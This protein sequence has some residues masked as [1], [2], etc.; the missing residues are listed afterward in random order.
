MACFDRVRYREVALG[1]KW[2]SQFSD[3]RSDDAKTSQPG[4]HRA[5]VEYLNPMFYHCLCVFL[6]I[7]VERHSC[8]KWDVCCGL[9]NKWWLRHHQR[10]D[11]RLGAIFRHASNR[12]TRKHSRNIQPLAKFQHHNGHMGGVDSHMTVT[13]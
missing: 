2:C 11:K 10:P 3:D 7:P 9:D 5:A 8:E 12:D 4:T 13:G 6:A 1:Q